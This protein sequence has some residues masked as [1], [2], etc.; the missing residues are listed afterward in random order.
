MARIFLVLFSGE[1]MKCSQP[2]AEA[3]FADVDGRCLVCGTTPF[4]VQG[5]GRRPSSD[6]QAWEAGGIA[7][8]CNKHAGTIRV[9]TGTL[10]GVEEDERVLAMGIKIY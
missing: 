7:V 1:R 9:E 4:R 8:C 5:T 3:D 6:G 10:F 2:F